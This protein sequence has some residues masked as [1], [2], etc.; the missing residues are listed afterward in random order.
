[1]EMCPA[2]LCIL[3]LVMDCTEAYSEDWPTR[4]NDENQLMALEEVLII[5]LFPK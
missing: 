3:G 2:N 1:M 5:E 4:Y